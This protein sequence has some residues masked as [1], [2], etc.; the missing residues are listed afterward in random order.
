MNT[1][2]ADGVNEIQLVQGSA[3]EVACEQSK[4]QVCSE[5]IKWVEAGQ[6]PEKF[7]T[8]GESRKVLVSR[9]MFNPD[10]FK[11]RDGY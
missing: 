4:A 6:M 8:K 3:T 9:S 10:M 1:S 5:V 2:F 7:K 11:V